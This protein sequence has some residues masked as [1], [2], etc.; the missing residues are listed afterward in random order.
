M[1]AQNVDVE[2][3]S[4]LSTKTK[5][6]L[7]PRKLIAR[8][9][10]QSITLDHFPMVLRAY[11][12]H[13]EQFVKQ[14]SIDV[15]F[16]TSTIPVT[17]LRCG[18][19]IVT[20]TDAVFHSMVDYYGKGF[21]NM[22]S[23]AVARGKWQEETA[24]RNC[25]I[26]ALGSTWARDGAAR[27]TDPDKLKVL[28]FGSSLPIRHGA[29]DVAR[30]AAEKRSIRKNECELLFVGVN[31]ERKGGAI[32]V[33]T[34]RLLNDTGIQTR[35]RVVGSRP[36]GDMPS[37][38]DAVGFLNKNSES[39]ERQLIEFYRSADFFIL[40]TKAEAAGI[41]FCEASSFGLPSL[42]YATG[43][44]PDYVRN[45]VNG[46]CI[47]PGSPAANFASE[48]QRLLREPSEYEALALRA[49]QEYKERLNWECSVRELVRYCSQCAGS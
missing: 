14:R 2:V 15:V 16:S 27:L 49:F 17:L 18:K 7:A 42:T 24:L 31:W 8:A 34:A 19:P 6:V 26:A 33:E 48:I 4:P 38:V 10:K 1:R 28:P 32:A 43:G 12:R 45:G 9:R 41:V 46:E 37:F 39:G 22:T 25:A 11:A 21:A 23:A 3:L 29:A 36:I 44:V 20:W 40:P 47:A 5:L 35:L 30:F 13:I